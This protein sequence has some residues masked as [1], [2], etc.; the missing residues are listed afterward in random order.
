ML[1]LFFSCSSPSVAPWSQVGAWSS[2]TT[3]GN[4][5]GWMDFAV[6]CRSKRRTGR[7]RFLRVTVAAEKSSTLTSS[8]SIGPLKYTLE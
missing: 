4:V 8:V 6:V 5:S 7:F 2:Y 3:T 1:T